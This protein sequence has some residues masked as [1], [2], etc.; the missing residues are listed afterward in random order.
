MCVSSVV[1]VRLSISSRKRVHEPRVANKEPD[2]P[3]P[4][5]RR[6][7]PNPNPDRPRTKMRIATKK[8]PPLTRKYAHIPFRY[9]TTNIGM[10][11]DVDVEMMDQR[12]PHPAPIDRIKSS[13]YQYDE[14]PGELR[15][16]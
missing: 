5:E 2:P 14:N 8:K 11:R 15:G 12:F 7:K 6:S 10:I 13:M 3:C 1:V 9:G 4:V 16:V